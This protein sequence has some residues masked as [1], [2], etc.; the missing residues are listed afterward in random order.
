MHTAAHELEQEPLLKIC[1]NICSQKTDLNLCQPCQILLY[2]GTN[3]EYVPPPQ[4][5]KIPDTLSVQT[6]MYRVMEKLYQLFQWK[7]QSTLNWF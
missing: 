7:G 6:A 2:S 3:A 1:I 5:P 4:P